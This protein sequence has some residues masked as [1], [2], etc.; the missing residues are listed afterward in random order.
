M[1]SPRST[2]DEFSQEEATKRF[3]AA[4][5]G[6]LKTPHTPLKKKP[7]VNVNV[8]KKTGIKKKV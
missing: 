1:K 2:D 8:K 4:L 5:R 3:E 6:A 7:K